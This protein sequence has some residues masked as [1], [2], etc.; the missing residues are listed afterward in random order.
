MPLL[1]VFWALLAPLGDLLGC[2]VALLLPGCFSGLS[3]LPLGLTCLSWCLLGLSWVCLGPVLGLP[4]AC[5]SSL[6]SLLAHSWLTLGPVLGL[7]WL[8]LGPLLGQP[9]RSYALFCLF[10]S[11]ERWE[12]PKPACYYGFSILF[13]SSGLSWKVSWSSLGVFLVSLGPLVFC[14]GL[15]LARLWHQDGPKTSQERPKVSLRGHI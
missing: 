14:L 4:W 2:L 3:W 11:S 9:R 10:S 15:L 6:G 12:T 13:G 7:S 1:A 8:S 5:L